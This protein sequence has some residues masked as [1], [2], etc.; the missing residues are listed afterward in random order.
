MGQQMKMNSKKKSHTSSEFSIIKGYLFKGRL[1]DQNPLHEQ[2][3][4]RESEHT[5]YTS[6]YSI[7]GHN[8][9]GR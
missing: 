8:E 9:V 5:L 6:I 3:T 7:R 1:T 2:E 4:G